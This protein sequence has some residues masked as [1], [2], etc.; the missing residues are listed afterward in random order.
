MPTELVEKPL[1]SDPEEVDFMHITGIFMTRT[2]Q[3]FFDN[4]FA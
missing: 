4:G 2:Q 3:I 1:N